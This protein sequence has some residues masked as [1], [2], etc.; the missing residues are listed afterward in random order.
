MKKGQIQP[1]FTWIFI[2]ILAV[3]VLFF[4]VKTI[5]QG[6]DF[7]DE[8]LL[9]DF[10]KNLEKKINDFYFL[11]V[12]SSGREDFLLPNGVTE[13][14]FINE[15]EYSSDGTSK[16]DYMESLNIFSNVFVFPETK[17][18]ENRVKL[19][20]FFVNTNPTCFSV[21]SGSIEIKFINKGV[22]GVLIEKV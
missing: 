7:K 17:F 6:E 3:T 1:I 12:D 4:G 19:D 13:V 11:D 18:K 8:I 10:Y 20:K 21:R 16:G 15:G 2:L 9:V 14:C 22:D 5:K